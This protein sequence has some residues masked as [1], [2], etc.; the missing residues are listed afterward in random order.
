MVPTRALVAQQAE[1]IKE[2]SH[3]SSCTVAQLSGVEIGAWDASKWEQCKKSNKVLVG[4]S[5]IFRASIVDNGFLKVCDISLCVLDECHQAVGNSPMANIMRDGLNALETP[6]ADRPRV[7]GLTASFV[8]GKVEN[9]ITKRHGLEAL[10]HATM[11]GPEIGSVEQRSLEWRRVDGWLC[12]QNSDELAQWATQRVEEL[13]LPLSDALSPITTSRR[14]A[15]QAA[16][17]LLELG[18]PSFIFYLEVGI[19]PELENHIAE[20]LKLADQ[21]EHRIEKL[22]SLQARLPQ[23]KESIQDAVRNLEAEMTAHTPPALDIAGVKPQVLPCFY[24]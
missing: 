6:D 14:V 4:T 12:P 22:E 3:V 24:V 11:W 2:H 16:H 8:N 9:L 7:V 18:L 17:V 21:P 20:Y 23:M 13:L 10:L 15:N 5:E 1:Y 19:F